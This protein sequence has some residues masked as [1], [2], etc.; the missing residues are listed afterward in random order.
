MGP[1]HRPLTT[2]CIPVLGWE[3]SGGESMP[4]AA[5]FVYRVLEKGSEGEKRVERGESAAVMS[6]GDGRDGAWLNIFDWAP[7]TN[8]AT[9]P[10]RHVVGPG[11]LRGR[12]PRTRE[13]ACGRPPKCE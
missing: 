6:A 3:Q 11:A 10:A 2:E 13:A 1:V 5:E 7:V 12:S 4:A 9:L 8:V